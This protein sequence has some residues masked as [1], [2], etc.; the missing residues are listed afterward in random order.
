MLLL[1]LV[2]SATA[3]ARPA[4][5]SHESSFAV[6]GLGLGDWGLRTSSSSWGLPRLLGSEFLTVVIVDL[7]R[8][9]ITWGGGLMVAWLV[10]GTV[11]GINY[12]SCVAHSKE[13]AIIPIVQGP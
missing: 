13:Y 12:K 8:L 9:S 3:R 11:D 1:R 7:M 4:T 5:R 10:T 6:F 2:F